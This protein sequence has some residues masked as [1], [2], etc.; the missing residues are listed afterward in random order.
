MA[1]LT[2]SQ[3]DKGLEFAKQ[4][5]ILARSAPDEFAEKKAHQLGSFFETYYG[6]SDRLKK[7]SILRL[8]RENGNMSAQEIADMARWHVN[9]VWTLCRELEAEK[10]IEFYTEQPV[11]PI[12]S[13]RRSRKIRLLTTP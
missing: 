6:Y 2:D 5:R 11:G 4:V 10:K 9:V 7:R 13:G 12:K 3:R 1:E 8:L